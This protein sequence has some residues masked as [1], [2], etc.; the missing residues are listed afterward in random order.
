M[1]KQSLYALNMR[2]W[3]LSV[4]AAILYLIAF[5]ASYVFGATGSYTVTA[6]NKQ[7]DYKYW[8]E[9]GKSYLEVR[10]RETGEIVQT[11]LTIGHRK[12]TYLPMTNGAKWIA[13]PPYKPEMLDQPFHPMVVEHF[14]PEA[15]PAEPFP[16][17]E[18]PKGTWVDGVI[19]LADGYDQTNQP[20]IITGMDDQIIEDSIRKTLDSP[21]FDEPYTPPVQLAGLAEPEQQQHSSSQEPMQVPV[22]VTLEHGG[23]AWGWILKGVG[24]ALVAA[25]VGFIGW[26]WKR[27]RD[28]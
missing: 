26:W 10:S 22:V 15:G 9:P 23:S 21:E 6:Q 24:A 14:A 28:A 27:R 25:A 13:W 2:L 4:Q 17:T 7:H 18:L 19:P 12:R 5:G 8:R 20:D 1:K 16:D 3:R 11:M